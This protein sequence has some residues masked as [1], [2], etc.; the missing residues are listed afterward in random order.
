M[1]E[2]DSNAILQLARSLEGHPA[3]KEVLALFSAMEAVETAIPRNCHYLPLGSYLVTRRF[4]EL[5]E[6]LEQMHERS[7]GAPPKEPLSV[8]VPPDMRPV[9]DWRYPAHRGHVLAA[10]PI[11][12]MSYRA[13]CM[14]CWE[15]DWMTGV[16]C[17]RQRYVLT[18]TPADAERYPDDL[19]PKP[20]KV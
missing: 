18:I 20:Q 3:K 5:V 16:E 17:D 15:Q 7:K 6:A 13:T 10:M 9:F 2:F 12:D 8:F 11:I 1:S 14:S 19:S 4:E